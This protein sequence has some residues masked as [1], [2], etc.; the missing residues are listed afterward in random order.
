MAFHVHFASF[1]EEGM[2]A[3]Q[4]QELSVEACWFLVLWYDSVIFIIFFI[5]KFFLSFY[6]YLLSYGI[7]I[8]I[9]S[10]FSL[11]FFLNCEV[12][13][14]K[15]YIEIALSCMKIKWDDIIYIR[16]RVENSTIQ[17]YLVQH[18]KRDFSHLQH[19]FK[20]Y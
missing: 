2:P 4:Q 9:Y 7:Y 18:L 20:N 13:Y 11:Y 19:H 6:W 5:K 3:S 1:N 14:I 8:D 12:C 17:P 16:R 15:N 10:V